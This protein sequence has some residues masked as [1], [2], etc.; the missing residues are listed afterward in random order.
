MDAAPRGDEMTLDEAL[1][2]LIP[3]HMQDGLKLYLD[4][5]LEPGGFLYA[6]LSN[7]LADAVGRADATNQLLLPNYIR[8]LYNYA[9]SA[10]WGSPEKVMSWMAARE[11]EMYRH[12]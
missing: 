1:Q 11:K 5:G 3:E 4:E 2:T 7:N 8:F 12:A 10:C 6:V 9:P